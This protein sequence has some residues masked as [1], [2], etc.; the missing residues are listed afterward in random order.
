MPEQQAI[1]IER[2]PAMLYRTGM[3]HATLYRRINDGIFPPGISLGNRSAGWLAHEVDTILK[4]FASG[5][6]TEGLQAK[7]LLLA[8]A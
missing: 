2:K 3:S 7:A 8:A 1:R 6:T 5:K 4:A